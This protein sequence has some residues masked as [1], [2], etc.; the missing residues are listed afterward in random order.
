MKPHVSPRAVVVGMTFVT[1]M[2]CSTLSLGAEHTPSPQSP[3]IPGWRGTVLGEFAEAF[4]VD[5]RNVPSEEKKPFPDKS[6]DPGTLSDEKRTELNKLV[7]DYIGLMRSGI[8]QDALS[9][10]QRLFDSFE[11]Y[12]SSYTLVNEA[13]RVRLESSEKGKAYREEHSYI[14]Y[15]TA[16]AVIRAAIERRLGVQARLAKWPFGIYTL[17]SRGVLYR[18]VTLSS[19]FPT[20]LFLID[21]H[22]AVL[23]MVEDLGGYESMCPRFSV[24]KNYRFADGQLF[25]VNECWNG[26]SSQLFSAQEGNLQEIVLLDGHG[27]KASRPGDRWFARGYGTGAGGENCTFEESAEG[28]EMLICRGSKRKDDDTYEYWKTKYKWLQGRNAFQEFEHRVSRDPLE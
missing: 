9:V 10:K 24:T 15:P 4:Q 12:V 3:R 23:R 14:Y 11:W 7:Q 8:I 16:Y 18:I 19:D 27:N 2:L 13:E 25:L 20:T 28:P 1:L 22:G 5:V 21:E 26:S 6:K 17:R